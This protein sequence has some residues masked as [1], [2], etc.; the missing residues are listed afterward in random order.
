MSK[1]N[2]EVCSDISIIIGMMPK[3]MKDKISNNFIDFIE[4]NKSRQYVSNINPNVPIN[5]QEIKKET[6]EML[7]MIYRDYLC[8]DDERIRLQEEDRNEIKKSYNKLQEKYQRDNLFIKEKKEK[9]K[10]LVVVTK[11]KWYKK[12]FRVLK[13]FLGKK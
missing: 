9:E 7:G 12:I 1:I 13:K 8:L 4:N 11:E 2:E 6:K 5:Q 3:E 10:R